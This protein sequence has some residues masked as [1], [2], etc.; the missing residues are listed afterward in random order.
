MRLSKRNCGYHT[1]RFSRGRRSI[2]N[3]VEFGHEVLVELFGVLNLGN[4]HKS[5]HVIEFPTPSRLASM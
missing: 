2:F 4:F 3:R 5:K 1:S